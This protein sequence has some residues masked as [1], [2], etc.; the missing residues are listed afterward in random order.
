MFLINILSSRARSN[1]RD[2]VEILPPKVHD[3][4]DSKQHTFITSTVSTTTSPMENTFIAPLPPKV[5][6]GRKRANTDVKRRSRMNSLWG[7]KS[8]SIDGR[9]ECEEINHTRRPSA[10]DASDTSKYS[11]L[12]NRMLRKS[13]SK[14][15]LALATSSPTIPEEPSEGFTMMKPLKKTKSPKSPVSPKSSRPH[16]PS[17]SG[18]VQFVHV[19]HIDQSAINALEKTTQ[20]DLMKD[21]QRVVRESRLPSRKLSRDESATTPSSPLSFV[22]T[23]SRRLRRSQSS[24]TITPQESNESLRQPHVQL[25]APPP[26]TSSRPMY[27]SVFEE[28]HNEQPAL[29]PMPEEIGTAITTQGNQAMT[30]GVDCDLPCSSPSL[31]E[32]PAVPFNA[33]NFDTNAE[34]RKALSTPNLSN[35]TR[36][37]TRQRACTVVRSGSTA[38]TVLCG[39]SSPSNLRRRSSIRR[40]SRRASLVRTPSLTGSVGASVMDE[41]WEDV[42]DYSYDQEAECDFEY[43]WEQDTGCDLYEQG[44]LDSQTSF[45]DSEIRTPLGAIDEEGK[46]Y[47]GPKM[48][49]LTGLFEDKLLLPGTPLS[50]RFPETVAAPSFTHHS[51]S[52]SNLKSH[53]QTQSTSSIMPPS[54][55]V[56]PP[57]IKKY[58]EEL[59]KAAELVDSQLAS[60]NSE[61]ITFEQLASKLNRRRETVSAADKA[62]RLQTPTS[63]IYGSRARAGSDSTCATIYSEAGTITPFD[64]TELITPPS[65]QHNSFINYKTQYHDSKILGF[66]VPPTVVEL[67]PDGSEIVFPE[68]HNLCWI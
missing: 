18:P 43:E 52:Y 28:S 68:E 62:A 59:N 33:L 12:K 31:P 19:N 61:A 57:I 54:H 15:N 4:F 20:K 34:L 7:G 47:L 50:A 25:Q 27:K 60:L 3:H 55:E 30:I 45:A 64:S 44:P 6:A 66:P 67:G 32:S 48:E 11:F 29:E 24:T 10:S 63:S 22:S 58:R 13:A 23:A 41:S 46:D 5:A 21:W 42:I 49:R 2:I 37:A 26:R 35:I 14:S 9:E 56:L 51:K 40:H 53:R 38:S 8:G 65:S 17:I 39:R 16:L 1:S 36:Q